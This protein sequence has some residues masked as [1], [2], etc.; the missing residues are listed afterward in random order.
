MVD[1]ISFHMYQSWSPVVN[2]TWL[3]YIILFYVVGFDLLLL[4]SEFLHLCAWQILVCHFLIFVFL[5]LVLGDAGL[6][7]GVSILCFYLLK[8]IVEI[9]YNFFLKCLIEST[10]EPIWADP[11]CLW[12]LLIISS[13]SLIDIGLFRLFLL[14]VLFIW[15]AWL[16]KLRN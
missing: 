5:V 2:P 10:S 11:F 7:E 4:C 3:W 12:T 8:E 9:L 6:K 14:M 13:I 16:F 1:Y 15:F